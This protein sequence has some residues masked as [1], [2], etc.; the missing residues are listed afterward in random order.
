MPRLELLGRDAP[1]YRASN[2]SFSVAVSKLQ[3]VLPVAE[4]PGSVPGVVS[5]PGALQRLG[6]KRPR[7]TLTA[8]YER[9]R[10]TLRVRGRLIRPKGVSKRRGCRGS[11]TITVKR[12]KHTLRKRKVG[13]RHKTCRYQKRIRLRTHAK[14]VTVRARFGGNAALAPRKAK[15]RRVRIRH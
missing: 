12:G 2:G 8:R 5:P 7:L 10:H 13:I 14:R 1:Y 15:A 4:R 6:R 11:V 9:K 3:V